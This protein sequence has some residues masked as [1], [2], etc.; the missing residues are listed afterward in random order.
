MTTIVQTD[1]V[2]LPTRAS[3]HR[4]HGRLG[5]SEHSEVLSQVSE[6]L[7]RVHVLRE[8]VLRLLGCDVTALQI[9]NLDTDTD[10]HTHLY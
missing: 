1:G 7:L 6:E 2:P 4:L 8:V 9:S 5:V 3:D 10:T